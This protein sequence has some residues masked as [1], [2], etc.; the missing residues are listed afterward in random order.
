MVQSTAEHM[1]LEL[2]TRGPAKTGDLAAR[3]GITRQATR[4][5]LD[6]LTAEGLVAH[7]TSPA[8]VGRPR[9]TWSLTAKGHGRFPDTHAQMTVELID[10]VRSE[11]GEAGLVRLIDRRERAMAA[12]YQHELCGARS[13]LE[14]VERLAALRSAEGYMADVACLDDGRFILAENHCPICAAVAACQGFCRSEL[15]LFAKLLA[16]ALVERVEH[17]L[18]GSRRCCYLV[19]P[20]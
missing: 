2:K 6:K 15:A 17:A 7:V 12:H 19:T 13:L 9:L 8:G 20:N 10:A 18:A 1:L 14:R 4:D 5:H 3:I 16:P 11:F